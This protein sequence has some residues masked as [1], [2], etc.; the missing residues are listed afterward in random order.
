MEHSYFKIVYYFIFFIVWKN[1]ILPLKQ[2]LLMVKIQIIIFKSYKV[3]KKKIP[4]FKN[5]M[6]FLDNLFPFHNYLAGL[7]GPAKP[8]ACLCLT[9]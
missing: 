7:G 6:R 5:F 1:L 4:P 8:K 3:K 9:T 2:N